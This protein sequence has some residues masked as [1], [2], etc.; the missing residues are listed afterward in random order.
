MGR[1]SEFQAIMPVRGK[2]LNCLKADYETIFKNEIIVDL[3]KVIGCG[4]EIQSRHNKDLSAF[5]LAGLKWSKII[6][7]TDA[8]FD[9]FHIRTMILTMFYRL[10]PTLIELG[11]I[12]IAES[13]LFEITQ[14]TRKEEYTFFAYNERE[15]S[16][17]LS[18]L[19][20]DR[21]SIQ[22]SKG[23]GE[24]EP[25]MMWQTTMNPETRRLIQVMPSDAQKTSMTFDLLL[26]DNIAGRKTFIEQN[27]SLYLDQLDIG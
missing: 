1:D 12:H 17:L 24:N 15:K 2:I 9:G 10:M 6:I 5:D 16:D 22:R 4:V 11:K 3:I 18:K 21:C 27:G 13:P 25:E 8:D 20:A 23:L 7:C 14:R 19:G 26:G